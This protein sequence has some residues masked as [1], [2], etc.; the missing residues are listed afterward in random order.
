MSD[1]PYG[2]EGC[3]EDDPTTLCD[4]CREDMLRDYEQARADTYD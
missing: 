1:C 2:E 4:G 3:F